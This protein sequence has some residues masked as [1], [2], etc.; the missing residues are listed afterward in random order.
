MQTTN[1]QAPEPETIKSPASSLSWLFWG[2]ITAPIGLPCWILGV[3]I[4][5]ERL[6]TAWISITLPI[7]E[8]IHGKQAGTDE[9]PPANIADYVQHV[10]DD[11]NLLTIAACADGY[12]L[13]FIRHVDESGFVK[14]ID[15]TVIVPGELASIGMANTIDCALRYTL[16]QIE[17]GVFRQVAPWNKAAKPTVPDATV[18]TPEQAETTVSPKVVADAPSQQSSPESAPMDN[19]DAA[20]QE[21]TKDNPPHKPAKAKGGDVGKVIFSGMREYPAKKKGD[22]TYSSFTVRLQTDD[23][24]EI[25]F[26]GVDLQ[27]RFTG[28]DAFRKGDRVRIVRRGKQ[29]V[30]LVEHGKLVTKYRNCFGVYRA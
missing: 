23:G 16:R 27:S 13:R 5:V 25:E 30:E 14:R 1:Q 19:I 15:L 3:I 9:T 28:N 11:R 4:G 7:I 29:P 26:N 10:L 18:N 21:A 8:F 22:R 17:Q 24:K 2:F 12:T 6:Q 20:S